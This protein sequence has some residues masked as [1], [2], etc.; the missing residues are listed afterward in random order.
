[1]VRRIHVTKAWNS[2]GLPST[3]ANRVPTSPSTSTGICSNTRLSLFQI[4]T[5]NTSEVVYARLALLTALFW[6]M[7]LCQVTNLWLAN[8]RNSVVFYGPPAVRRYGWPRPPYHSC[9]V[10]PWKGLSWWGSSCPCWVDAQ[11]YQWV[12]WWADSRGKSL[13]RTWLE[14]TWP[15][16]R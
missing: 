1:M 9:F 12:C 5:D 7:S 15:M 11:H 10:G 16:M 2:L 3:M 8:R 4:N 14:R 6:Y 13:E